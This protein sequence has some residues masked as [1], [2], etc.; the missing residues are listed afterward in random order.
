[1][2]MFWLDCYF[3]KMCT[4]SY[5]LSLYIAVHDM[6]WL[7]VIRNWGIN[8]W[9]SCMFTVEHHPGRYRQ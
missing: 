1:M 8:G 7:A 2:Y 6:K 4:L 9:T 3:L 5:L